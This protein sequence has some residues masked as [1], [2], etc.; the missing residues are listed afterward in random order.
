MSQA[1]NKVEVIVKTA[2]IGFLLIRFQNF[3]FNKEKEQ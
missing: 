1:L 3:G 2:E